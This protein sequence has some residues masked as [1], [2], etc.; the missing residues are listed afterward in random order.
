[1][2]VIQVVPGMDEIIQARLEWAKIPAYAPSEEVAIRNKGKWHTETRLLFPGYI[3]MDKE[4]T[5]ELFHQLKYMDG[6]IKFLGEPKPL[7]ETE[8]KQIRFLCNNG[9]PIKTSY[10]TLHDNVPEFTV[11]VLSEMPVEVVSFSPRQ[12]RVKILVQIGSLEFFCSLPAEKNL[13]SEPG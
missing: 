6:F 1:M 2:Y 11:G 4:Y 9:K 10:Y 3:F 12:R 5:P 8:E 7:S 13:I